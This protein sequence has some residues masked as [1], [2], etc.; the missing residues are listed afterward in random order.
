MKESPIVLSARD[1]IRQTSGFI[2]SGITVS[3]ALFHAFRQ[4]LLVLL[5]NVRDAFAVSNVQTTSITAV[6]EVVAGCIDL[7]GGVVMDCSSATGAW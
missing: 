2:L 1:D 3:H 4:S 6:Q 5:P 7:P